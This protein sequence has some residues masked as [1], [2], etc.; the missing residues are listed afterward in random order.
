MSTIGSRI[1]ESR[2]AKGLNQKQLAKLVGVSSA[3]MSHWELDENKPNAEKIVLLCKALDIS[4]SYLLDFHNDESFKASQ[5][6]MEIIRKYRSLRTSERNELKAALDTL[7]EKSNLAKELDNKVVEFAYYGKIAAAG[8]FINSF[9]D[10]MK[11]TVKVQ[12]DRNTAKADYCIGVSGDSMEPGYSDGD[13][14]LVKAIDHVQI[15]EVGIFQR[16]NDIY[17]KQYTLDGL[18]SFKEGYETIIGDDIK[19]LGRVLGKAVVI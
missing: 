7:T 15:G 8:T 3:V 5:E 6:E 2:E 1:V 17:I 4:A 18:K 14:V 12:P 16:D 9:F 19:C 13:I 10:L 11:R